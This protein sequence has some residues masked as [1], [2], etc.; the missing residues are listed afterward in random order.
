[1]KIKL[2]LVIILPILGL[3][4]FSCNSQKKFARKKSEYM[5][6]LY[7]VTKDA[8]NEA[9]VTILNDSVK[10]L[11]PEHLLFKKGEAYIPDE[12]MPLVERFA[13]LLQKH[14][15]TNIL[16]NGYTDNTGGFD[17]NKQLSKRRADTVRIV[18]EDLEIEKRRIYTWGLGIQN[19]I[20]D[21]DTEDGK[22]KNRRVEFII[23]YSYLHE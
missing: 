4:L 16:I 21:N 5:K 2:L 8:I 3:F 17:L 14:H 7:A 11:F 10:V 20:G 1:M 19:P 12:S 22:R 23:L 18:L 15:R 9:E 6:S 13:N